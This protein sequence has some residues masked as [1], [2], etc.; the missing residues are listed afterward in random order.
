M[1]SEWHWYSANKAA[2]AVID[3]YSRHYSA[4]KNGK[5]KVHWRNHGITPPAASMTLLT[6]GSDA[7]FVWI[8][9]KF[10][11]DGLKGIECTVF[12]NESSILSSVLILEAE[13]LALQK[14]RDQPQFFTFVKP[15]AIK[16]SNAGYCFMAAGWHREKT[17]PSGLV[18]LTK[19]TF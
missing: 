17:L 16:S 13:I 2:P 5:S 1:F 3:L 9:S 6:A 7:L 10:R 19:T 18:L 14:W 11:K 15:S 12:R 8:Q 4:V